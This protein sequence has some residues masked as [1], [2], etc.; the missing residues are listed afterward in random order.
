[1][2]RSASPPRADRRLAL[3]VRFPSLHREPPPT[4]PG[5]TGQ[6]RLDPSTRALLAR[7]R[8]GDIALLDEVDLD[9]VTAETL[10]RA[11]RGGGQH[12][13]EHQR[14][15][16][17]AGAPSLVEAGIPLL[18]AVGTDVVGRVSD[19][20]VVRLDGR[21]LL[22]GHRVIAEGTLQDA[23]S[24]AAATA[25]APAGPAGPARGV[26]G[27][28]A[29]LPGDRARPAAR[30]RRDPRDRHRAGRPPRARRVAGPS[31][32]AGPGR[33]PAL[34]PRAAPGPGRGRRGC[35]RP[36]GRRLPTRPRGR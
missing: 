29:R 6:V 10:V 26:R 16:P 21:E 14:A 9:H 27:L 30:R 19:G 5:V 25:T 15:L 36:A 20:D 3:P 35:R 7:L 34:D 17:G 12:R 31:R 22:I 33:P 23:D 13:P 4:L 18:D 2:P 8:P 11:R 32:R 28:D 24:V 1:M